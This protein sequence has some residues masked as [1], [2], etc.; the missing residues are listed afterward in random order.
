[1]PLCAAAGG[2]QWSAM[3]AAEAARI[4]TTIFIGEI[5]T[6]HGSRCANDRRVTLF[7]SATAFG[8]VVSE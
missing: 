7:R 5:F 3:S 2:I 1:L 6:G 8:V 4:F